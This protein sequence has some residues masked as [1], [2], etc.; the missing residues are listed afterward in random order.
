MSHFFEQCGGFSSRSKYPR[1]VELDVEETSEIDRIDLRLKVP[2]P[3]ERRPDL[4]IP[5]RIRLD[6]T[7]PRGS[8]F[9]VKRILGRVVGQ[10]ESAGK[11]IAIV[12]CQIMRQRVGPARCRYFFGVVRQRH[13]ALRYDV[14]RPLEL[15]R[16]IGRFSLPRGFANALGAGQFGFLGWHQLP[17]SRS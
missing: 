12:K 6:V 10:F 13:Y 3:R 4:T 8:M 11:D 17:F 5:R 14:K 2:R 7:Y 9:Q 15:S 1:E 16:V